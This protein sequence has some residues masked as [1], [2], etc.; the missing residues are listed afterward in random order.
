MRDVKDISSI[1]KY[2]NIPDLKN[3]YINRELSWLAFNQRVLEEANNTNHP[4]LE[5]LKFLSISG[6]N[7]DEFYMVRVAGLHAQADE[8]VAVQSVDGMTPQEQLIE[9]NK[10]AN[11]LM[12]NQQKTWQKLKGILKNNNISIL[13]KNTITSEEKKWCSNYF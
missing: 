12:I 6:S 9:V 2:K 4:L 8:D 5:R 7:L 1:K 10:K 3:T 13:S 11:L